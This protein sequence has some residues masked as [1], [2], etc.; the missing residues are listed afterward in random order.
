MRKTAKEA[1]NPGQLCCTV[2][3]IDMDE[4]VNETNK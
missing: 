1:D 3:D 2:P 4:I